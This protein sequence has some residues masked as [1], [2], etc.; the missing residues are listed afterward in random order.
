MDPLSRGVGRPDNE[1]QATQRAVR[2]KIELSNTD[3]CQNVFSYP[4]HLSE[5]LGQT[6]AGKEDQPDHSGVCQTDAVGAEGKSKSK[7][8]MVM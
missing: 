7:N 5:A 1:T 3:L 6:G 8:K 4:K 2:L